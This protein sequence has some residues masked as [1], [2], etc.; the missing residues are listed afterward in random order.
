MAWLRADLIAAAL[1]ELPSG[2]R[3]LEVGAGQGAMGARLAERFDYTAVEFDPTSAVVA[4]Q[5]IE[6]RGGRVVHGDLHASDLGAGF[7]AVCAF[8]VLEHLEDDVA[9]LRDWWARLRPGGRVV[10][11]VPAWQHRFTITDT[12]VGHHRR[13][14]PPVLADRLAEAGFVD[15][16][17]ELYGFPLGYALE[18]V[19]TQIAKRRPSPAD[20]AHAS[21]GSGRFLQPSGGFGRLTRVVTWP[22]RVLHR[23]GA[24]RGVGLVASA[25][26]PVDVSGA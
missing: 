11:S 12:H 14:D 2:A 24:R 26:R 6:P 22:F 21:A 13:Y 1:A 19:R 25:R 23:P 10:L 16:T 3:V 8:E 9:A 20:T 18:A 15:I 5:R 7:D 17:A 4:A